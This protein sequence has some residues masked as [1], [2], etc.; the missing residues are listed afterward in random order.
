[1][2]VSTSSEPSSEKVLDR[3]KLNYW[4]QHLAKILN[5]NQKKVN[6]ED[7]HQIRF[8]TNKLHHVI[9]QI[10]KP[11]KDAFVRHSLA[12]DTL[13]TILQVVTCEQTLGNVINIFLD[14]VGK[15]QPVKRASLLVSHGLT[16]VLFHIL[17]L[18]HSNDLVLGDEILIAIHTLLSRIGHKDRKFAVKAR[19]HQSLMVTL[20]LVK[21]H[22]HN[23]K[24]LQPLL[25]VLKFYTSNSVNAS[26]LGKH[27]AISLMFK[28]INSCG[29]RH[30]VDL[31]LALENLC[32]MTKSKSNSARLI[33]VDGIPILLILHSDWQQQ[34]NKQRYLAIRRSILLILK[35]ITN[36]RAG[37]KAFVESNGIRTLYESA[38]EASDS[39]DME[40]LILLASVIL[41]KCCPRN[42]LPLKSTFSPIIFPLPSSST[43]VPECLN[44]SSCSGAVSSSTGHTSLLRSDED[45]SQETFLASK[46]Q[47]ICGAFY[48]L[49][50]RGSIGSLNLNLRARDDSENSGD[51]DEDDIDSD[52][53]RFRTDP[54][55]PDEDLPTGPETGEKRSPED[56]HMYDSFFPEIGDT[57]FTVSSLSASATSYMATQA[58]TDLH[59]SHSSFTNPSLKALSFM[60]LKHVSSDG[61]L[62]SKLRSDLQ[63]SSY[64]YPP[65]YYSDK[66]LNFDEKC[67]SAI[68]L[69]TGSA[70]ISLDI[71]RP[72]TSSA[73]PLKSLMKGKH[74]KKLLPPRRSRKIVGPRMS[75]AVLD[76]PLPSSL[77]MSTSDDSEQSS[78]SFFEEYEEEYCEFPH[79][80]DLYSHIAN[81]TCSAYR[82]QKLSFPDLYGIKGLYKTMESL[83]ARKFGVQRSKIFEDIDRMIHADQLIDLVVY[84]YD[85]IVAGTEGSMVDKVNL[86]NKDELRL[87]LLDCHS[88]ALKFNSQFECGNLRKAVQVREHEYD[89]ILNPDINSNHHHQWFYFEVSN[90]KQDIPYRFN[91]VNC[92]KPN[93]QFNFGMQPLLMSVMEALEGNPCWARVG[94]D[95]C[96]YRNHFIRDANTAGGVQGKSYYTATFN[97]KFPHSGD[98]CYISYH[99]PYTYSALMTHLH[100]WEKQYDSSLIYF[101]NQTLCKTLAGNPVPLLTITA[102]PRSL[103]K[104][105]LEELRN[106]PYVFLSSRV[107]P[108]ES[109]ASWIMKGTIDFLLSRKPQ[110]QKVREMFI[111]KVVPMLNPDGV[112]NGNHRSSLVGEDL[113]RRWG[114]P[115]SVLHP[116]IYHTKGLLQYLNLINKS[117]LVYCDYHGHSRRK[118]IFLYGCSPHQSWIPNDTQNPA[119]PCS[120]FIESYYKQLPRLLHASCPSFSLQ[121]CSFVVEKVKESTARVVVWR[122][123]GVLRSYT[124]ESSY[125]GCDQGKYKDMHINTDM[126]EEMG[127]KFCETLARISRQRGRLDLSSIMTDSPLEQTVAEDS[128]DDPSFSGACREIPLESSSKKKSDPYEDTDSDEVFDEDEEFNDDD[129]AV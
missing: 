45:F 120:K 66:A 69:K 10:E 100:Q 25:Q 98:V 72:N 8:A 68:N 43:H 11:G 101:K 31:R 51:D 67:V 112:I 19:L 2:S 5:K 129:D 125:C 102:Q 111:F 108:G 35:N 16:T 87:G 95:I 78:S 27:N 4:V 106:R 46:I 76:S 81:Q 63:H 115:C 73:K 109:N 7:V 99:Y 86:C 74:R 23:F 15:Q 121:N 92:E 97:I 83:Y 62:Y 77:L 60:P 114:N 123:I 54:E 47:L 37:R 113:N 96:Y 52:D 39:R 105:A 116:T 75:E 29:K 22:S 42:K 28:V 107:H 64:F 117:P 36:L 124:M 21:T 82:F 59:R 49:V 91:I 26:Y 3:S 103:D 14:I 128:V 48:N 1:M 127:Q 89:L 122:E 17:K 58:Y 85:K 32:N 41:R 118:N 80:A 88:E 33:N 44:L 9:Q 34:D 55:E 79:D 94:T 65:H 126:L 110:A 30:T 24:N 119:S 71:G 70:V 57:D 53:E 38:L 40:S 6:Y 20:N 90:M 61:N 104:E 93:S 50:S 13:I 18:T 84:D 56:L 12:M